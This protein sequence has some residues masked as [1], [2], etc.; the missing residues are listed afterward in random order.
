LTTVNGVKSDARRRQVMS[1][2]NFVRRAL[3]N[4]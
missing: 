3:F 2:G 4:T 1:I